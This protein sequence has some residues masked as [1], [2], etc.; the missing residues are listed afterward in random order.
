MKK[1]LVVDDSSANRLI[2]RTILEDRYD[3]E[4]AADGWEAVKMI[5]SWQPDVVLRDFDHPGPD[6]GELLRLIKQDMPSLPVIIVT[7]FFV[8]IFGLLCQSREIRGQA[9]KADKTRA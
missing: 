8:T 9:H 2:I 3:T 7:A 5:R 4:E 6:G 1:V